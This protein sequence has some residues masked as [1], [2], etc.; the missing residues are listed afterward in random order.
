MC[1]NTPFAQW[2]LAEK[3][4]MDGE[5]ET[6]EEILSSSF[7]LELITE[8]TQDNDIENV[9]DLVEEFN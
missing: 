5:I 2:T 9:A 4:G 6:V 7:Q 3:I 8:H 1:S